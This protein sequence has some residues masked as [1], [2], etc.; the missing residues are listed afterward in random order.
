MWHEIPIRVRYCETDA[1]GL[2]HHG[3]YINYFEFAR[4]ELFRATG[5]NYREMEER[6]F[7]FVI[8]KVEVEYKRPARF[9]D[10]L[11]VMIRVAKQT[12]AKIEHEYEVYRGTELTTKGR[13]VAAC[14]DSEGRVQR[15]TD[16]IMF[17][18]RRSASQ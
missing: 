11:R 13:S 14:V 7:F 15:I 17:G 12:A 16:D 9:D 4:T 5:G 18:D 1:M 10:E 6:G 3:N 8:V 2:L